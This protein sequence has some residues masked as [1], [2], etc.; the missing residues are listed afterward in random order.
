MHVRLRAVCLTVLVMG[1]S[2]AIP[3]G[4]AVAACQPNHCYGIATWAPAHP[5]HGTRVHLNVDCMDV[6]NTGSNFI[7]AEVWLIRGNYWVEQGMAHGYPRNDRYWFWADNRPNYGYA[8]HDR[9]D[10]PHALNTSYLVEIEHFTTG[11]SSWLVYQDNT[12]VGTSTSNFSEASTR[13]DTG[14]ES[15][16]MTNVHVIADMSLMKWAGSGFKYYLDWSDPPT[17]PHATGIGDLDYTTSWVT[18]YRH[19][20][21]KLHPS[22][23]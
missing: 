22:V 8:E 15:T 21:S 10:L 1:S 3:P 16:T 6:E 7:T 5:N 17:Y 2:W 12:Y 9:N 19:L 14:S 11:S 4:A 13:L 18:P 20:V 23:C